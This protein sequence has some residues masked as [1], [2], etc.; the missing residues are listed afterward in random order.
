[1]RVYIAGPYTQGDVA[2]N[3][4]LAIEAA[5]EIADLGHSP[6]VPHLFHFWHL[7]E[8]R[9]YEEWMRI[10]LDWLLAAEALVRLPG[11]SRGAD[12][13]CAAAKE[14][15]IPVYRGV[16]SFRQARDLP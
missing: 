3:V 7:H 9:P 5:T 14:N 4:R 8:P 2:V 11:E 12:I 15:G 13:E 16:E 6:M 1:V 10:D